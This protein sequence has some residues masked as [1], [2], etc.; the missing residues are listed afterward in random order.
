[1]EDIWEGEVDVISKIL[2]NDNVSSDDTN[3]H[4]LKSLHEEF[5][6]IGE[7]YQL[8]AKR[9]SSLEDIIKDFA[10]LNSVAEEKVNKDTSCVSKEE[11]QQHKVIRPPPGFQPKTK[12]TALNVDPIRKIKPPPGFPA[13]SAPDVNK[14]RQIKAAPGLP[15]KVANISTAINASLLK[16]KV[17]KPRSGFENIMKADT[18]K[19]GL[20]HQQPSGFAMKPQQRNRMEETQREKPKQTLALMM[21][22]FHSL[23]TIMDQELISYEERLVASRN[24]K[25]CDNLKEEGKV[26]MLKTL[27]Y[28]QQE[29]MK[30]LEKQHEQDTIQAENNHKQELSDMRNYYENKL[31]KMAAQAA[32]QRPDQNLKMEYN[33]AQQRNE[34]E[35]ENLNAMVTDLQNE[36]DK[37]TSSKPNKK[38]QYEFNRALN[39]RE[40]EIDRL[41]GVIHDMQSELERYEGGSDEIAMEVSLFF[42][43]SQKIRK[44]LMERK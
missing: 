36:L 19:A 18:K 43:F 29:K 38:L 33:K 4:Q 32:A 13:K 15:L 23:S 2:N 16:T 7:N 10:Q 12:S 34:A 41:N 30:C 6:E 25:G 35:I 9:K 40:E 39:E 24:Q 44:F 1:M 28:E 21:E 22:D 3:N 20:Q 14:G 11:A 8:P 17:V 37:Q 27:Y 42:Y 31:N 5:M 26:E